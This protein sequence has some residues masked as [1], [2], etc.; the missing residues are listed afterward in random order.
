MTTRRQ[1]ANELAR[2]E[3]AKVRLEKERAIWLRN[4]QR[5]EAQLQEV[6]QA[7]VSLQEQLDRMN[8]RKEQAGGPSAPQV[9]SVGDEPTRH[10]PTLELPRW[11]EVTLEY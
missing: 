1:V 8:A 3:N 9:R 10:E 5:A 7:M 4:L 2:L 6:E 11:R